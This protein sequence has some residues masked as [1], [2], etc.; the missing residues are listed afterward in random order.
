MAGSDRVRA[1]ARGGRIV[2]IGL[3]CAVA[4][5]CSSTTDAGEPRPKSDR[6]MAD[7]PLFD[8]SFANRWPA[9]MTSD[10]AFSCVTPVPFGVWDLEVSAR[11]AQKQFNWYRFANYGVAHCHAGASIG[12]SQA[13]APRGSPLHSHFIFLGNVEKDTSTL[14]IWAVQIGGLDGI[15]Y[16]LLS[17]DT[18]SDVNISAFNVLQTACPFTGRNDRPLLEPRG[19]TSCVL[20]SRDEL[21]GVAKLMASRAPIGTMKLKGGV[22]SIAG[23]RR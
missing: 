8:A 12:S 21:A 9:P 23:L 15:E 11:R 4:A 6:F 1:L 22:K 20:R 2:V 10:G 17:R 19:P 18:S 13:R 7:A 5:A 14:E 16:L 3:L